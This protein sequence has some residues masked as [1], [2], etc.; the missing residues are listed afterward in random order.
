MV[1]VF[2]NQ[3]GGVGKTTLST[4]TAVVLA[5][6]GKDV[7]LL[8]TDNQTSSSVWCQERKVSFPD[9]PKIHNMSKSGE[10]DETLLDLSRR[11]Q[12]VL[13]DI[14]G[15][16]DSDELLSSM[17]VADIL[18][19]PFTPSAADTQTLHVMDRLVRNARRNNPKL[20]A[21]ACLNIVRTNAALQ[22]ELNA[23]RDAVMGY[24]DITLMNTTIYDRVCYRDGYG[25]GLGVT[26]MDGKS[27]SDVSAR[28]EILSL[29]SE[30][31]Y[32]LD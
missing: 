11:Y 6:R 23:A 2:G 12:Y 31:V 26:E 16:G 9:M 13:V 19:M 30:L 17:Q 32:D 28:R 8:D 7:L 15:R 18:L 14:A 20:K 29:V 1:I 21:C 25:I 4:N 10:I 3:K 5:Q 27:D 24:Q 22:R